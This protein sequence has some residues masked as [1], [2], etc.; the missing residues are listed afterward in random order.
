MEIINFIEKRTN[1]AD[2][3]NIDLFFSIRRE[4]WQQHFDDITYFSGVS[5]YAV[6]N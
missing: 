4:K 3:S 5:W 1:L 2:I 6:S